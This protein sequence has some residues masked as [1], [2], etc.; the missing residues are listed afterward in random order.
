[1]RPDRQDYEG[2][3]ITARVA[4]ELQ[5]P[6]IRIVVNKTPEGFDAAAVARRVEDAYGCPV[7]AVLPHSDDL[8]RLASEGI[9]AVRHPEPR[10]VGPLPQGRREPASRPSGG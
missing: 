4:Q 1:M 2:T 7:A 3:G 5:V 8:M 9:F 10:A 6:Q